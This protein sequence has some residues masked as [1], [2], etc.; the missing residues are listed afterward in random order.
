MEI[1]R[2]GAP[3]MKQRIICVARGFSLCLTVA[4]KGEMRVPN[5]GHS[6]T[7][8]KFGLTTW[9]YGTGKLLF[10]ETYPS[11]FINADIL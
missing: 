10:Y 9:F 1:E 7:H 8:N 3:A 4:P 2:R 11:A 6:L 5:V